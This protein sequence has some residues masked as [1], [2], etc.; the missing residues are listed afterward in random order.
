MGEYIGDGMGEC[1]GDG[2]GECIGDGMG[3]CIGDGMGECIG[4][5]M[6]EYIG[7]GEALMPVVKG[8]GEAMMPSGEGRGE[9]DESGEGRGEGDH[10]GTESSWRRFVSTFH[11]ALEAD[12]HHQGND[13]ACRVSSAEVPPGDLSAIG[14][15]V[16]VE[17]SSADGSQVSMGTNLSCVEA[18]NVRCLPSCVGQY[19]SGFAGTSRMSSLAATERWSSS[20]SAAHMM[21]HE[22]AQPGDD[23]SAPALRRETA[24]RQKQRTDIF[25]RFRARDNYFRL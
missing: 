15:G 18:S 24:T 19:S 13:T 16:G 23:Y 6:G 12:V 4:D 1:I 5:G 14:V 3:E 2:M 21:D 9:G 11:A 25:W 20:S 22:G 7:D 17:R 8:D 10:M